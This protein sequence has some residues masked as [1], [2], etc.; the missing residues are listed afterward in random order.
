MKEKPYEAAYGSDKKYY[1][2]GPASGGQCG[3]YGGT[4]YPDFRFENKEDAERT[5]KLMNITYEEGY[6]QAQRDIMTALGVK[7]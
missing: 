2:D 1:V 7:Q 4:L 6:R 3:Y 5:A